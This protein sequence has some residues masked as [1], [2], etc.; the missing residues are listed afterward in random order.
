MGFNCGIVGLPNVGKSTLFNALTRSQAAEAANF[1]FTTI[2][3]NIG[4]VAVPDERL[5]AV[6]DIAKPAAVVPTGL[7][8]VDIAGLV[9]GASK[10][11][12]LGNQFLGQIRGVDAVI[13]VLRCFTEGDV[14]H[15]TGAP[16]PVADA[17]TVATELML[18]DMESLNRRRDG[19]IKKTRGGDKEA[20]AELAVAKGALK[21]LEAGRPAREL[22]VAAGNEG[23]FKGLGLLTAK[24]VLY[25]LNVDEDHAALG[26]ELSEKAAAMAAQEGAGWVVISARIEEEIA[27]LADAAERVEFLE[28]L[29]LTETGLAR[30]IHAGYGLL[31][32]ITFFTV[33]EKEAHAWTVPAGATAV[34]AAAQVHTDF[35]KGFIAAETITYDDY[36]TL[37]GENAAKE[38]GKMR[39]EGRDYVVQDGDVILFRFNV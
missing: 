30:V 20:E 10:G 1:P 27:Q 38:A 7:E 8:F 37:G 39:A 18:A 28:S 34:A 22:D 21:L 17:G 19:L 23:I 12:G 29:G 35:A 36:V 25:V 24:P 5:D 26:S 3:P 15:V 4:R 14:T 13:H 31:G 32:L 11:E 6:A 2:E 9:E 16:D 33:N